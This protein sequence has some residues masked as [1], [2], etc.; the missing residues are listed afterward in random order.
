MRERIPCARH[1]V[2]PPY[3][4]DGLT[5]GFFDTVVSRV[6]GNGFWFE[7]LTVVSGGVERERKNAPSPP[8]AFSGGGT[9]LN[10]A[11]KALEKLENDDTGAE[12]V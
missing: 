9:R 6:A 5:A 3:T 7:G 2:A 8:G 1:T 12:E 11:T 4:T 10:A